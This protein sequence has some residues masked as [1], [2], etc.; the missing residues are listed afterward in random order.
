MLAVTTWPCS[1]VWVFGSSIDFAPRVVVSRHA[2]V[3]SCTTRAI[4]WTPSPCLWTCW[5]ISELD[6]SAVVRTKRT[7]PCWRTQEARV[8]KAGFLDRRRRRVSCRRLRDKVWTAR[9]CRRRTRRSRCLR[10]G[11]SLDECEM[12]FRR[13]LPFHFSCCLPPE[14]ILAVCGGVRGTAQNRSPMERL[15]N[16]RLHP[17]IHASRTSKA[18]RQVPKTRFGLQVEATR[19]ISSSGCSRRDLR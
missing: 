11:D 2:E 15:S 19:T 9:R 13:G 17:N 8:A 6:R 4:V 12:H 18:S 16:G 1:S 3:A 14:A 7:F 10:G 5:A